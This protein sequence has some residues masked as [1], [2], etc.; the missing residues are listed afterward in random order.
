MRD[1]EPMTHV[2][3]WHPPIF[4]AG[5]SSVI[6]DG[7][8]CNACRATTGLRLV[9]SSNTSTQE[10]RHCLDDTQQLKVFSGTWWNSSQVKLV[11][12]SMVN[13]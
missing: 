8:Q 13:A 10:V 2:Y 3:G 9:T 6:S 11:A 1:G 7:A 12:D 4:V 5:P